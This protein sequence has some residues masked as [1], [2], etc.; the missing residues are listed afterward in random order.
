VFAFRSPAR[1]LSAGLPRQDHVYRTIDESFRFHTKKIDEIYC[2][3][4]ST[5]N[6]R[7]FENTQLHLKV[8]SYERKFLSV[9]K[10]FIEFVFVKKNQLKPTVVWHNSKLIVVFVWQ[11]RCQCSSLSKDWLRENI[12][13]L[14]LLFA[15]ESA[16]AVCFHLISKCRWK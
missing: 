2:K 7:S 6:P 16:Q 12:K 8:V 1:A 5:E 3:L 14:H 15:Y 4:D 13:R 11:P 9:A 10:Q